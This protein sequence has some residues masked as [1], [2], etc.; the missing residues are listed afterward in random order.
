MDVW[1]LVLYGT[2]AWLALKS[3]LSLMTAHRQ[4]LIR[5]IEEQEEER[6]QEQARV[7]AEAA[8][9]KKKSRRA[10]AA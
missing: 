10:G 1:Q 3:L 6:R 8:A 9:A 4:N 2:A 5:E 7:E